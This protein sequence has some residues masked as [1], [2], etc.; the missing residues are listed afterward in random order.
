VIRQVVP[1]QCG[2]PDVSAGNVLGTVIYFLLFNLGLIALL[3]PIAVPTYE[4]RW[5]GR[6]CWEPGSS[7]PSFCCVAPSVA[8]KVQ[9]WSPWEC[10]LP[11]CKQAANTGGAEPVI[12]AGSDT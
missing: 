1:A 6:F 10:P 4:R 11:S 8:R 7:R 12:T 9:S 2:R 3:T 5:T